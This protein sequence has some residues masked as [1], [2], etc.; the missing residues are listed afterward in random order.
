MVAQWVRLHNWPCQ[1]ENAFYGHMN[2]WIFLTIHMSAQRSAPGEA[3]PDHLEEW[4]LLLPSPIHLHYF[5]KVDIIT[6]F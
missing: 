5:F 4:S 2:S 3:F 6:D 1:L